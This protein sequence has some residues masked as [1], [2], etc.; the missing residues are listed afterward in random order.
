MVN[1]EKLLYK[2]EESQSHSLQHG[3]IKKN[4]VKLFANIAK[5]STATFNLAK[6]MDM[7]TNLL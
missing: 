4:K 5:L 3:F 1:E 7:K 6:T 2:E